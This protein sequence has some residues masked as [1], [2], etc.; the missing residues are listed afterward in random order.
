M[1]YE[2]QNVTNNGKSHLD[3]YL[4]ELKLQFNYFEEL[5]VFQ[6]EKDHKHCFGS[7][8]NMAC[9]ISGI[10]ITIVAFESSFSIGSYIFT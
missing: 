3:M 8:A 5:D 4:D 6:Y 9:D 1:E 10:S 2:S 7:V